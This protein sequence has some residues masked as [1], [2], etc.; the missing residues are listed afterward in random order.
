MP[1][2]TR[3]VEISLAGRPSWPVLPSTVPVTAV[4]VTSEVMSVPELVMNSLAPLMRHWP[5]SSAAVV[6]VPP[7]SEP[8][9]GS[10]RPKPARCVPATRSGS[11][12]C[13]CSSVPNF[14]SGMAP[15]ET[16][17]SRVMATD[18]LTRPSCS[19]ARARAK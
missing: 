3:I 19:S 1:A 15:R 6:W 10:V 2:G 4:T 12:R 14:S 17:A 13:F 5:S 7:A 16:P 8:A 11:Q 9:P 18:W